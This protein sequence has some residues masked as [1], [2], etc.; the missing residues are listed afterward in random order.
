MSSM[1]LTTLLG[2]LEGLSL[3]D[4]RCSAA[5]IHDH[6]STAAG[7][8]EWWQATIGIDRALR[9][10]GRSRHAGAAAHAASS[11]VWVAARRHG[12]QRSDPDVAMLARAA[13]DAGRGLVVGEDGSTHA[14]RLLQL[15]GPG[16]V[17]G[18]GDGPRH[19]GP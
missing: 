7:E 10:T 6:L 2:V 13:A 18:T 8:I 9:R 11:A 14:A 5:A 19:A 17:G 12:A 16:L 15:W 1:E 4:M 3:E